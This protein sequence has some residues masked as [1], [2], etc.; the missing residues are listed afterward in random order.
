MID[1]EQA[2][3][4]AVPRKFYPLVLCFFVGSGLAALIYEIVWFQL[5]EF[6][7]GSTATSLAVLLGTFM[8]GMCLGSLAFARIIAAS[9]HP[10][11][12]Y[13]A[14]ELGIGLI[15]ILILVFSSPGGRPLREHRRSRLHRASPSERC[16]ARH[17]C[18]RRRCSWAQ[19]CRARRVGSRA[20]TKACPGWGFSI[21][22]IW[23][24]PSSAACWP[25]S[26]C[27]GYMT[28]RPQPSS[29]LPSTRSAPRRRF[30][31]RLLLRIERPPQPLP[32]IV[33]RC[34]WN[35]WPLT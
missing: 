8:G 28:W 15:A 4:S 27:C 22:A 16:C 31:S 19:P 32:P 23:P 26:T 3:H 17:S 20:R 25:G 7:I 1:I 2:S 12:V 9:F 18:W 24:A 29:P 30:C 14:L 6:I 11:R 5:L 35:P 13:A 10:L 34:D 33:H 21:P